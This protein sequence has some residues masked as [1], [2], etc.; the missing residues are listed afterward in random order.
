M[1]AGRPARRGRPHPHPSSSATRSCS[2]PTTPSPPGSLPILRTVK[3]HVI[4]TI[5]LA[6]LVDP[7]TGP[8][9][10]THRIRR[11]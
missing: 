9:A 10:A 4:V 6:D 7:A 1:R 3:P 8:G 11:R 5:P 2:G